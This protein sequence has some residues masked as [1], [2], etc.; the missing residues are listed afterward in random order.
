MQR[1]GEDFIFVVKAPRAELL[2]E[3]LL[4]FWTKL[5]VIGHEQT[6]T[7]QAKTVKT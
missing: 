5:V 4:D 6:L 2:A 3:Y 1:S 7:Q